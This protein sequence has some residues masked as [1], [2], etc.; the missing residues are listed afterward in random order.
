MARRN[1]QG[2]T[3][4]SADGSAVDRSDEDA[5]DRFGGLNLGAAFFGWLIAIAVTVLLF[6]IVA[7]VL[8]AVGS[9]TSITQSEAERS[10]G[11]I[12][13]AA[14]IVL[15]VVL[16][17][18]YYTGGYVAGRMSRYNGPR[19]GLGVWV[20]GVVLTVLAVVLGAVFGSKYNILNQVN[21][22][23]LPVSTDQL[24][25]GGIVTAVA[26]VVLTLVAA[27]LG[28]FVGHRYHDRVDRA[29]HR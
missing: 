2:S 21:L 19:Q 27:M 14:G 1:Q 15:L 22:P 23:R 12:G 13:I 11:T 8:T 9:Q 4:I 6:A 26:V 29:A 16:A 10:A 3:R 18:A 28:G 5:R 20:I 24:S 7:A 25:T 17:V